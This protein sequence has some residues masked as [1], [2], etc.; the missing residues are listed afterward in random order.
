VPLL[1]QSKQAPIVIALRYL[2]PEP[3]A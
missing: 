2:A 3:V 1:H